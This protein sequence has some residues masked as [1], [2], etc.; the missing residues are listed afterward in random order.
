[1]T[2]R[3]QPFATGK[4]SAAGRINDDD[5]TSKVSPPRIE[6]VAAWIALR[7]VVAAASHGRVAAYG[8]GLI[9]FDKVDRLGTAFDTRRPSVV[10][11]LIAVYGPPDPAF[12]RRLVVT[13]SHNDTL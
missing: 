13:L 10:V 11:V 2:S 12:A 9:D 1:M 7:R 3:R 8:T 4:G 5:G 6:R